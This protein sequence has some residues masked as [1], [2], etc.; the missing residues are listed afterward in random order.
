MAQ[1]YTLEIPLT[2]LHNNEYHFI[3]HYASSYTSSILLRKKRNQG[4]PG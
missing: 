2:F 4:M 3:K 1:V